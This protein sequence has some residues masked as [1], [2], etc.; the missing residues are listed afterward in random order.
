MYILQS[1]GI[2]RYVK[3]IRISCKL[4]C[5]STEHPKLPYC[6]KLLAKF[7]PLSS[8]GTCFWACMHLHAHTVL[9]DAQRDRENELSWFPDHS[10]LQPLITCIFAYCTWSKTWGRNILRTRL[11]L[12]II[13]WNNLS[14]CDSW[15]LNQYSV[16]RKIHLHSIGNARSFSRCMIIPLFRPMPSNCT[17]VYTHDGMLKSYKGF[18]V[19]NKKVNN[20]YS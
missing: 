18:S 3:C 1:E 12:S 11:K 14:A 9:H 13:P 6:T 2:K 17:I 5:T 19:T 7:I 8:N 10:H 4:S 15:L 20:L 16:F